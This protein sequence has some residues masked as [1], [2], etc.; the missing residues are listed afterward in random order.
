MTFEKLFVLFSLL[1][2][3]QIA[4]QADMIVDVYDTFGPD[5]MYLCCNLAGGDVR[6]YQFSP[7]VTGELAQFSVA[8]SQF[9]GVTPINVPLSLYADNNNY[10]AEIL[11]SYIL[12]PTMRAAT[13]CS[14]ETVPS[15]TH[16]MLTAGQEYWLIATIGS[17]PP[18]ATPEN[19]WNINSI[20]ARGRS[21]FDGNVAAGGPLGA[22]RVESFVVPEPEARELILAGLLCLGV[23]GARRAWISRFVLLTDWIA[24]NWQKNNI[25]S[26]PSTATSKRRCVVAG[27]TRISDIYC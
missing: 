19:L 23:L 16:P 8:I 22:F 1:C 27:G 17:Q 21:Y 13:C 4:A 12:T 5:N 3:S 26:Q 18:P 11:E 25:S 2:V 6:G 10:P 7:S 9:G 24:A 20:D 15:T 14:L